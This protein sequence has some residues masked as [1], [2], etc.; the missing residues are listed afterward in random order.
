MLN[1]EKVLNQWGAQFAASKINNFHF[2]D[3][4][5]QF[6]SAFFVFNID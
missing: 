2:I 1:K 5:G 6:D 3:K 4:P